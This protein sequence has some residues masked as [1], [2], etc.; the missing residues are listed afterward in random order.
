MA[1]VAYGGPQKRIGAKPKGNRSLTLDA[2]HKAIR[3]ERTL[4]RKSVVHSD[5]SPRLLVD[6]HNQRKVGRTIVKGAWKGCRIFTLTLEE[7]ATCPSSCKHWL[8]CYGNNMHLSRRHV[9]DGALIDRLE[10][11]VPA[12]IAKHGRIAIRL[13][14]LGDFG[15]PEDEPL[16]L[17]YV[18]F[19]TLMLLQHEGLHLFG[20]T[21]HTLA[22]PIGDA[23]LG[24]N[25]SF[26][27]RC[28]IRFS[29]SRA[30][31]RLEANSFDPNVSNPSGVVC[32][33]QTEATDCCATCALCW[34]TDRAIS[35]IEH[36][37]VRA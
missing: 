3:D 19:W 1:K 30:P 34:S 6:G 37:K 21:A 27:R 5:A 7:R 24:M 9:L 35:F 18:A 26:P 17:R 16:A 11:E 33:A 4:F 32:P 29:N 12:L 36:G 31:D 2:S 25:T 8:S 10:A 22:D 23:I 13:H 14:V 15:R 28:R 20:F